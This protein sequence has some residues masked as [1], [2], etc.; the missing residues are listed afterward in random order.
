MKPKRL[1]SALLCAALC[2][3]LTACAKGQEDSQPS[4]KTPEELAGAYTQAIQAARDEEM[5]QY[6]EV[7]TNTTEADPTNQEMTFALLGF[8]PEDV[9]AYG[10][11]L[12]LMNVNA[13]A[14]VAAKPAEGKEDTVKI[15]LENYIETQKGNFEFYLEDQFDIAANAKLETLDDGTLLLV[16]CEGQDTVFDTIKAELE[17]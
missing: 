5:N 6:F 17:K 3:S 2:L 4:A 8:T 15:G 1:L 7:M 12:S 13:Y 10:I 11:S 14:I 16:M 9:E